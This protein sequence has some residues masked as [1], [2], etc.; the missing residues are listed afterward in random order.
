MQYGFR[1]AISIVHAVNYLLDNENNETFK[2]HI[3]RNPRSS[4]IED[5]M[6]MTPREDVE[7]T[8]P[9]FFTT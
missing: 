5:I 2:K 8:N 1:E 7:T 9:K 4:Y 6:N 3:T